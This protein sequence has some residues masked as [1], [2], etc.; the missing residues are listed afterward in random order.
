MK[1]NLKIAFVLMLLLLLVGCGTKD[2]EKKSKDSSN[3]KDGIRVVCSMSGTEEGIKTEA[4]IAANFK[5]SDKSFNSFD[6]DVNM[7]Y[8]EALKDLSDKEKKEAIE[9]M[10][11]MVDMMKETFKEEFGVE[12]CDGSNKDSKLNITCN[13]TL[14]D[15]KKASD[16]EF[17]LD[18]ETTQEDFIKEMEEQGYTCKTEEISLEK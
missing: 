18:E 17:E 3:T 14:E 16:S 9:S 7:D 11:G 13:A 6:L 1:K 10:D 5:K 15:L 4:N 8:A 2:E 12:L